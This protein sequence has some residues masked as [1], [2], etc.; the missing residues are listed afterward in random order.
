MTAFHEVQFPTDVSLGATGGPQFH[1]T[2]MQLTSGFEKRN[3]DWS[4]TRAKY[5]VG[6]V[7]RPRAAMDAVIAFFYARQGRAYGFRFKD[8]AD[9]QIVNQSIGVITDGNVTF[10]AFKSYT[11][12]GVTY[13]RPIRKVVAGSYIVSVAGIVLAEG[14]G[15]GK[16]QM[17]ITTGIITLGSGFSDGS[18]VSLNILRFDVPVRFDSDWLDF[19]VLEAYPDGGAIGAWPSI[20]LLEIRT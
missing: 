20:P 1:T 18:D 17:D 14:A 2:I 15:A 11:S 16:F 7:P 6:L 5:E 19:N 13:L 12:G 10:Q 3:V 8:W 4:K 9:Y